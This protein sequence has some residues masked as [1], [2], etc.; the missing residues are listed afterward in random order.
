MHI[1]IDTSPHT[2]WGAVW[3]CERCL[4]T[5]PADEIR[6]LAYEIALRGIPLDS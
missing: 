2:S 4:R 6:R 3:F 5:V 1:R